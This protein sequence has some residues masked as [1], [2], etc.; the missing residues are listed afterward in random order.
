MSQ[1]GGV[2]N[3]KKVLLFALVMALIPLVIVARAVSAEKIS[4]AQ[5]RQLLEHLGGADFKSEQVQIRRIT[6]GMAGDVVVEARIETAWRL[7]RDK[8]NWRV[9]EVR[10]GDR[11]WESLEL[12]EEA[13]R[14]EK[15]RRTLGIME[16]LD[17]ALGDYHRDQSAFV[18]TNRITE[19]LDAI[20]PRYLATPHRLDLWGNQFDYH[21]SADR[22]QLRSAG[23]DGRFG[24]ADDLLTGSAIPARRG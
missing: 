18:D 20:S 10:L 6:G 4:V 7:V 5:V 14:R 12:V 17:R 16:E 23:P 24:S 21:G 2:M 1:V 22:Y 13:V 15:V 11:H 8:G 9:A 3:R 19:L